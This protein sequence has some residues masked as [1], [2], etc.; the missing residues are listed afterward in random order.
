MAPEV[1]SNVMF[2][3]RSGAKKEELSPYGEPL[4]P[5][6]Q[7]GAR[8]MMTAFLAVFAIIGIRLHFVHL[9]PNRALNVEEAK[10]IGEVTLREPRG[11]IYDRNAIRLATNRSV[12]SLWVDATTLE[13]PA[14]FAAAVAPR[15]GLDNNELVKRLTEKTPDG[16][17]YKFKWVKR[18]V[19]EPA[20]EAALADLLVEWEKILHVRYESLRH[21]PQRTAAAQLIGFVN[22]NDEASEG[23][24]LSYDKHLTS[25]QGVYRARTDTARR[26]LESRVLE[27]TPAKA[28][29]ALQLTLDINIQHHLEEVLDQ[30]IIDCNASKGM[31]MLMDPHTGAILALAT[32]P[33][34]DPNYYES[35]TNEQRKNVAIVD[36]FEPGSAFKIVTASGAIE[37][38]LITPETMINCENGGFNPYGHYIKD[39]HPLGVEP[40][41]HCFAESSN[42]ATIKVAKMLG[43]ERLDQWIRAFGFGQQTSR[44]FPAGGESKGI[45]RAR[46]DWNGLSMGSLPMGQE[47]SVTMPQLA[48]AFAVIANGGYLVEP[49]FVERAISKDGTVTYQHQQDTRKRVL[50]EETAA[51][52]RQLLHGVVTGGTGDDA[53]I[54]EYDVGGKTGT[55]QMASTTGRGYSKDRFTTV[56]AGIAP[57]NNPKLVCVIVVKEPMIKLHFGGYVC[58]PVFKDVVRD[59]LVRMNVPADHPVEGAEEVK[60][61]QAPPIPHPEEPMAEAGIDDATNADG[62]SVI[63]RLSADEI[64]SLMMAMED[65][66][67]SLDGLELTAP[68]GDVH[69]GDATLPDLTGMTKRQ[70]YEALRKLNIPW[71]PQGVGRVVSQ[72]PAAGTPA[73]QVT[74]CAVEFARTPLETAAADESSEAKKESETVNDQS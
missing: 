72:L 67:E 70:A 19:T 65:Q 40:F 57:V 59:A 7:R 3:S 25:E 51:T 17:L 54:P 63:E 53:A 32:R 52:M 42:V 8:L 28:G 13:D 74:L 69:E 58:G 38:G 43:P 23:V 36:V 60:I 21:Y 1:G 6:Q 4:S 37:E 55:A 39:F 64:E 47:I 61:A 27:Y 18:W 11:E 44:D 20:E 46:K 14:A 45:F 49:Y 33:S 29:E 24:E 9:I 50:S 41:S 56:F 73:S 22:R 26:L 12:P 35:F 10:H 5:H 16:K 34:Y 30:R 48:R 62:D 2:R 68:A 31:G 15:L 66:M 71:D